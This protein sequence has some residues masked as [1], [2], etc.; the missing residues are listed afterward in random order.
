MIYNWTNQIPTQVVQVCLNAILLCIYI[1]QFLCCKMQ[2]RGKICFF[3]QYCNQE[4]AVLQ[5]GCVLQAPASLVELGKKLLYH[6]RLTFKILLQK[7]ISVRFSSY[8]VSG[9]IHNLCFIIFIFPLQFQNIL[10]NLFIM[11]SLVAFKKQAYY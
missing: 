7:L 4:T 10:M 8:R 3:K 6:E 5:P 11:I 2:C 1:S 9:I